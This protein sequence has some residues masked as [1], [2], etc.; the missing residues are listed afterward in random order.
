MELDDSSSHI[1]FEPSAATISN[2]DNNSNNNIN[3]NN[4]IHQRMDNLLEKPTQIWNVPE[5]LSSHPSSCE[6]TY[7]VS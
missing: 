6:Y 1:L 2:D 5:E 4:I 7:S 3:N